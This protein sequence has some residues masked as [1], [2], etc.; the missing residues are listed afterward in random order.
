M[1]NMTRFL[2]FGLVCALFLF[3]SPFL[4]PACAEEAD[5]SVPDSPEVLPDADIDQA[6]EE[7]GEAEKSAEEKIK[8][9]SDGDE[10]ITVMRDLFA[11]EYV[12]GTIQNLSK[13][14][15]RLK[16]FDDGDNEAVDNFML[17][18]E[19]QIYQDY[20]NNDFEWVEIRE[21]AKQMLRQDSQGFSKKFQFMLPVYLGEYDM[22]RKGFPL[23]NDTA[24]VNSRRM[25]I[26]GNSLRDD[27]CGRQGEVEDYPRNIMLIFKEPLTYG[28]VQVD[29]HVAQAYLLRK[30]EEVEKFALVLRQRRY[31]R[32][33]YVR[34]RVDFYQYQGNVKGH[35][36]A[37]L[38]ILHG[39]LQGV[40]L[41]EDS[42]GK[43]LMSS[44]SF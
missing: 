14:Y 16:V 6:E 4:S 17:I 10:D 28:F 31:E 42:H 18:N 1:L 12:D 19:C 33:A 39:D 41:F 7:A 44:V 23:I 40:D 8:D 11:G 21:A 36:L 15:W 34:L 38:A 29:E 20:V 30:Q 32:I 26:T 2:T 25:E 22:E 13:L 27:V 3:S 9:M 35:S 37:T 24:F 5:A 43:R